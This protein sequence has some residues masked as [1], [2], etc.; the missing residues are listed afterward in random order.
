M[1]Q[2]SFQHTKGPGRGFGPIAVEAVGGADKVWDFTAVPIGSGAA[3]IQ[4]VPWSMV[5]IFNDGTAADATHKIRI[6]WQAGEIGN[7]NYAILWPQT[8][9]TIVGPGVAKQLYMRSDGAGT[10]NIFVEVYE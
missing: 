6:A 10:P 7:G 3:T 8:S 4:I 5:V 9:F 1:I 2:H